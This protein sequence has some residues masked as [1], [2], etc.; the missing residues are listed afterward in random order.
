M[1]DLELVDRLPELP[2]AIVYPPEERA[3]IEKE[4]QTLCKK[5]IWKEVDNVEFASSVVLV[6]GGKTG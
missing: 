4:A 3:W 2:R 1:F 5:G 6:R